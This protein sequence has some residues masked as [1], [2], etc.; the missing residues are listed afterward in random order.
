MGGTRGQ[1]PRH[2]VSRGVQC[3][4]AADTAD[5]TSAFIEPTPA[6]S[7]TDNDCLELQLNSCLKRT[8]WGRPRSRSVPAA[9]F[10][11]GLDY[12]LGSIR[13]RKRT[14]S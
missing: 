2:H 4:P 9:A 7:K 10:V 5:P 3:S 11:T 6:D 12:E 1:W 14:S 13:V 8:H